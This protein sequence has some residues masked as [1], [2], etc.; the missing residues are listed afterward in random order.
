MI[1]YA[2]GAAII[3]GAIAF[4]DQQNLIPQISNNPTQKWFFDASRWTP[5]TPPAARFSQPIPQPRLTPQQELSR[6]RQ[7]VIGAR[8]IVDDVIRR[9][10]GVCALGKYVVTA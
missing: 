6:A 4:I 3:G 7:G 2:I 8:Q 9:N 5:T 1:E 10:P